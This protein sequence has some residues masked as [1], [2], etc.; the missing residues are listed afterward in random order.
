MA[1]FQKLFNR[2]NMWQCYCEVWKTIMVLIFNE[3]VCRFKVTQ[4]IKI[5]SSSV[6]AFSPSNRSQLALFT[7]LNV[8]LQGLNFYL[9]KCCLTEKN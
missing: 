8:I 2:D 4:I 3:R 7:L 9:K 6:M 1:S 5:M